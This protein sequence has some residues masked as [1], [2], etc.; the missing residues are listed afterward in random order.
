MKL[1]KG[2]MINVT[3]LYNILIVFLRYT[4]GEYEMQTSLRNK[5]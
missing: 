3:Y 4:E 2:H 5:Y 1:W